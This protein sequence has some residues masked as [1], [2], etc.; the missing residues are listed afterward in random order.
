LLQAQ[1]HRADDELLETSTT[2]IS[3]QQL[4]PKVSVVVPVYLG[5]DTIQKCIQSIIRQNY[6]DLQLI[7]LDDASKDSSTDIAKLAFENGRGIELK[8][9]KH[10]KNLGIAAT[11]NEAFNL[12]DGDYVLVVHQ[13]CE[14]M[15]EDYIGMAVKSLES[16]QRAAV[17]CGRPIYPTTEFSFFEKVYL[18]VS[19]HSNASPK[20]NVEE[21]SFA[22]HK[23]DL[24]VKKF[25][26]E[27]GGFDS[28]HFHASAEDQ[29]LS[30]QLKK[31]GYAIIRDNRLLYIQRYGQSV[32]SAKG[33]AK[34]LYKYGKTQ[35]EVMRLTN[36]S[37]IGKGH[38]TADQRRRL[39]NRIT[40][41][42]F[43]AVTVILLLAAVAFWNWMIAL[44]AVLLTLLRAAQSSRRASREKLYPNLGLVLASG[45]C[46]LIAD[47]A[48]T[49]G[50]ALGLSHIARSNS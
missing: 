23:C 15:S 42:G 11:L 49:A 40:S 24:F 4:T 48:Y 5:S 38:V 41:V 17:V 13:D 43:V 33:V 6:S 45:Y 30:W 28:E 18:M 2:V 9:V 12:A 8:L 14:L 10:E 7:I 32:A 27:V 37:V 39:A 46:S 21:I 3:Q 29:I 22:E 19:D 31:L 16:Q 36:A 25:V 34:K 47:F 26:N 44:L 50:F 20:S 35:S 1:I